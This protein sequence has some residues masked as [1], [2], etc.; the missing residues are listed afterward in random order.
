MGATPAELD[1]LL[2]AYID[3]IP[4]RAINSV[5]ARVNLVGQ[6]G[7][8]QPLGLVAGMVFAM[9]ARASSPARLA[10]FQSLDWQR[11]SQKLCGLRLTPPA[12]KSAGETAPGFEKVAAPEAFDAQ[13]GHL[14]AQQGDKSR[15]WRG[16][17]A[18]AAA[19]VW[20]QGP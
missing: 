1:E 6:D 8:L 15:V 2:R 17:L 7:S 19:R 16:Q 14:P 9:P 5:G 11:V 13:Y 12:A 20:R 3:K 10:W 18:C 4:E